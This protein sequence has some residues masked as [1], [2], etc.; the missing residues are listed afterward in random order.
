MIRRCGEFARRRE[1]GSTE[2]LGGRRPRTETVVAAGGYPGAAWTATDKGE[3]PG[4][5][6]D[7]PQFSRS[8]RHWPAALVPTISN[9]GL[10]IAVQSQFRNI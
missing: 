5:A 8:P 7:P 10:R 3:Y 6:E 9:A 2:Q 4:A 1:G